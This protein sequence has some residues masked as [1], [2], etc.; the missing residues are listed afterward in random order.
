MR[1]RLLSLRVA[2]AL[3][4]AFA[5]LLPASV[6]LADGHLPPLPI[7]GPRLSPP[8]IPHTD[9]LNNY[10]IYNYLVNNL[11]QESKEADE[12]DGGR[13]QEKPG[14]GIRWT[15]TDIAEGLTLFKP[16]NVCNDFNVRKMWAS[17]AA[18][19]PS[20]IWTDWYAGWAP[21][22]I[23]D[24]YYQAKNVTFSYEQ[25]VGPGE[26]WGE[27][28]SSAK[29]ASH[30]P[31]AAGFGSPMLKVKPGA[32]VT[33]MVNYLIWDH[34][35]HGWDYDWASMG[36]KPDAAGEPAEY[37]NGYVR[38]EW[39]ELSHTITAGES[40]YIMVLLQ[41]HSPAA[42]NSNIYF[43]NVRIAVDGEY[44]SDCSLE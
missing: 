42:L 19:P 17:L 18:D 8:P 43:D 10:T 21:Y 37:V 30:Q 22:A 15:K 3:C 6:A 14:R 26:K 32:E 1:T 9:V 40:G 35:T 4:L 2:L 11:P 23:D 20:D 25:A 44:M 28:E 36:L 41:G 39:A 33:V 12:Y 29:I 24:G 31:Y 13:N 38:G 7:K 27:N 5:L 16:A 34:D